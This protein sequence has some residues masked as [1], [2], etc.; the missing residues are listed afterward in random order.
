MSLIIC[1]ECQKEISD[2]ASAC[3]HCGY[4]LHKKA[5]RIPK[6]KL[7]V[8]CLISV[9]IIVFFIVSVI[10]NNYKVAEERE[11]AESTLKADILGKELKF[12][13]IVDTAS[14]DTADLSDWVVQIWAEAISRSV[15]FNSVIRVLYTGV[16]DGSPIA[17]RDEKFSSLYWGQL[18]ADYMNTFPSRLEALITQKVNV[19]I[20]MQKIK[21]LRSSNL[22]ALVDYY[23]SYSNLYNA[24]TEPSGNIT[25]F[26]SKID[27][28]K[29]E[30][31]DYKSK[32]SVVY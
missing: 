30:I 27:Q 2:T 9:A 31:N 22:P 12:I 24:I 20:E 7:L 14:K 26:S 8:L 19:D 23:N 17:Y 28:L 15:D 25:T 3:P 11:K 18:N 13:E 6:K 32:L 1:P 4:Q 5:H 16:F 29:K 10:Q 21:E